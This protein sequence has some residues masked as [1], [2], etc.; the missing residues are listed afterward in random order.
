VQKYLKPT[1]F[2]DGDHP[3]VLEKAL[4]LTASCADDRER[5]VALFDFVRDQIAY[6]PYGPIRER[7]RYKASA[8]LERGYG[9]CIQKATLLAA[10][11]RAVHIPAALIFADIQNV[12]IPDALRK[13][14]QTDVFVFHCYN[15]ILL[16]GKWIKGTCA[17]DTGMC[18]RLDVPVV[19]FSGKEDAIFP[20]SLPDG[21]KFVT[22]LRD[23][24][25]HADVPFDEVM[26]AFS[27]YYGEEV[28]T[29]AEKGPKKV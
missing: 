3:T 15:H 18:A 9:Y 11:L 8:T 29:A 13:T 6:N 19:R 2:V 26:K 14:L 7:E 20:P 5:A 1:W 21:R 27:E 25:P 22:Y 17:F 10:L 4:A 23:R 24:G 12:L 28:L 16:N